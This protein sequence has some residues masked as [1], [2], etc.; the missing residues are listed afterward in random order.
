MFRPMRAARALSRSPPFAGSTSV[1]EFDQVTGRLPEPPRKAADAR[2]TQKWRHGDLEAHA[3]QR[4][5]WMSHLLTDWIGGHGFLA[6][7]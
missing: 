2:P 1:A 4:V 5:S 6:E 7:L 3:R